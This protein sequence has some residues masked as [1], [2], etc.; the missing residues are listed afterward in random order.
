MT[1]GWLS[2]S[3]DPKTGPVKIVIPK[4]IIKLATRRNRLRRLIKEALRLG[5]HADPEKAFT[6]RVTK[7]PGEIGLAKAKEAMR[8]VL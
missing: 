3:Q 5:T 8:S 2:L 1:A 4:K 7:D 6:F